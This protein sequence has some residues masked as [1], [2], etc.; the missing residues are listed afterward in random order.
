MRS[1]SVLKLVVHVATTEL[2]RVK[3][4]ISVSRAL[5]INLP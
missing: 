4:P 3:P 1:F 2:Y 5:L